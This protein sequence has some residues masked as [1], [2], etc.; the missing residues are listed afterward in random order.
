MRKT[1]LAGSMLVWL[2]ACSAAEK[3]EAAVAD[4]LSRDLQLAPASTNAPLADGPAARPVSSKPKAVPRRPRPAPAPVEAAEVAPAAPAMRTLTAGATFEAS[5]ND[6]ITSRHNKAGETMRATVGTDVTDVRGRVVV[7]A[8]STVQLR[9]VQ[10]APADNK[11]QADGKLVLEPVSVQINGREY[12]VSGSVTEIEH[13]LKGRGVTTG[14]AA[15]VGVGTAAGA[16]AGR[17]LGGNKKGT[18]I[19]GVIGA[20]AG[21]AY[22][23]HTADRDVVVPAGAK[24]TLSLAT[25]LSVGG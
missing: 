4:S 22:A 17:L 10:L 24:M 13:F 1:I 7:P 8:G 18:I 3:P 21:T 9:I 23:V 5:A 15:K 16:I 11:S 20:G 25:P 14:Q 12:A 2:S 19:G 6:T